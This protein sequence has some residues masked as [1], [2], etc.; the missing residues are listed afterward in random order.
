MLRRNCCAFLC[1]ILSFASQAWAADVTD[2]P[3]PQPKKIPTAAVTSLPKPVTSDVA[4]LFESGA[5]TS[6][7][8]FTA[9][10]HQGAERAKAELGVTYQEYRLPL[11][12]DPEATMRALLAAGTKHI[13]AVGFQNVVPVMKLAEAF[14]AIRFT[15]VDGIVPPLFA[16]VQSIIFKDNEGAFLVGMVAAYTSKTGSIGFIGG[17]DVPLIR[18]FAYGY[19]QGAKYARP[20][21][22]LLTQ[23]VGSTRDAWNNQEKAAAIAG[24]QYD[25]GADV[26]FAAAGG[27]GLGVLETAKNRG[28]LAIGVDTNQ[29]GLYP[30]FVLTSLIKR[31]D[32]AVYDALKTNK[33]G[34]WEP[35]L[36]YLGVKDNMLD[37]TVDRFNKDLISKETIERVED[38]KE[39]ILRGQIDVQPYRPN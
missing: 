4:V 20:D 19:R 3:P 14:P 33:E 37:F 32:L 8:S 31:V 2:I 30:G 12:G 16:N 36:K 29:N 25:E 24:Q 34:Q 13:I 35:G 27:S 1:V 5:E 28:R 22:K 38:A 17:M 9:S 7:K 39:L 11:N 6:D 23:M 15:V 18:N 26:I 21:I 10:A